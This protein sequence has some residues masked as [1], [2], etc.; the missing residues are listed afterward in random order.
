MSD[1]FLD[2]QHQHRNGVL[3]CTNRNDKIYLWGD[4]NSFNKSFE[5][6]LAGIGLFN[7]TPNW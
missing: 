7:A 5:N 6:A 2:I 1:L 4:N 3:L